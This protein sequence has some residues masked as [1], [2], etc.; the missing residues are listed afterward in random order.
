MAVVF[1]P[2]LL[3]LFAAMLFIT[4]GKRTRMMLLLYCIV[5]VKETEIF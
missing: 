2:Y 3:Y 5:I 4:S 1:N